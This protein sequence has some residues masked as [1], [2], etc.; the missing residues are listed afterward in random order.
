MICAQCDNSD[1]FNGGMIILTMV[2]PGETG[3]TALLC[4]RDC[5]LD[6]TAQL[7]ARTSDD[8][9]APPWRNGS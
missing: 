7:M 2:A 6:Y 8:L 1:R 5:L 9:E 4:S 3:A